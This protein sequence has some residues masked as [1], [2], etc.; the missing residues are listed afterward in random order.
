MLSGIYNHHT[1]GIIQ[2]ARSC[3]ATTT[4]QEDFF[5]FLCQ[6]TSL[7]LLFFFLFRGRYKERCFC[8]W[9]QHIFEIFFSYILSHF[10][11]RNFCIA[12]FISYLAFLGS[13]LLLLLYIII[14]AHYFSFLSPDIPTP[15][16]PP[17]PPRQGLASARELLTF[18]NRGQLTSSDADLGCLSRI[19]DL[20]T[21]TKEVKKLVFCSHKFLKI[22]ANSQRIFV[23]FVKKII[24]HLI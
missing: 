8:I 13:F 19:P 23:F 22:C 16:H 20:T 2:C 9:G 11:A 17:P 4:S 12:N 24:F 6:I 10:V 14:K 7:A 1:V 3:F 5:I 21:S 15:P 18:V